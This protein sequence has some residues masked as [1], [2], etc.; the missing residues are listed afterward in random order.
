MIEA[1]RA[2]VAEREPVDE[3]ER[4]SISTFLEHVDRLVSP[5]DED[6][7]PVHVTGSAVIL[8]ERGVVLHRHRRLGIWLQPGGHIDVG[9]T[10]WE[11]A[12]REAGRRPGCPST[13]RHSIRCAAAP[14]PA[15]RRPPG[16][17]GHTHLDLRYLFG[18]DPVDPA[19][20]PGESPEVHWLDLDVAIERADD[21]L[22]GLLVALRTG[23]PGTA[24]DG[25][26]S[27]QRCTHDRTS[28]RS[29]SPR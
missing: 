28:S 3:R 8:G 10:P 9:E 29:P 19:P 14:A 7:S 2:D 11:A 17:E 13:R 4:A 21:G 23:A 15:R 25:A 1:I 16:A 22:R 20:P 24:S 18:A 6:A 26:P 5:F 27:D 12:W